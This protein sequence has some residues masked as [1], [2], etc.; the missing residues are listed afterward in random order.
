[1]TDLADLELNR[2]TV[3][4]DDSRGRSRVLRVVI[5]LGVLAAAAGIGYVALRRSAPQG[6]GQAAAKPTVAPSPPAPTLRSEP[7]EDIVLPPLDQTDSLVR[8]LV[9]QLS[10]HP[11]L[12][13]WLGTNGL[14]QN[15]TVVT[16]NIA[17]GETPAAHLRRLAPA[18]PFRAIGTAGTLHLDPRSYQRY[19]TYADAVGGLDA[20][21][22]ARLYATL[23]PRITEASR[24]LGNPQGDFDPVLER[25]IVELLRV[26]IVDGEVPLT[27]KIISYRFADP[28][29]EGLSAA[30]RQFLRMG[31]RNVRIVQSKL[32]EIAPFLGIPNSRLP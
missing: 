5:V 27:A 13:A 6:P 10:A 2:P 23:K 12:L 28:R 9:Q 20:R 4:P 29:L 21:G 16:V 11:R 32:R 30:Q 31:P 15:F 19:D 22:A 24:E 18:S 3:D 1:M 25:A 7:G 8:Q 14:I 17:S 26:P